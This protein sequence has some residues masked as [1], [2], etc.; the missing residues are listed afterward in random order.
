MK[1]RIYLKFAS[2]VCQT[3]DLSALAHQQIRTPGAE[4]RERL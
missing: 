4:N 1:P 2:E 3:G